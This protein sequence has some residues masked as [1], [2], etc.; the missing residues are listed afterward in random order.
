MPEGAQPPLA[1]GPRRGHAKWMG[2]DVP[3]GLRAHTVH[4]C[5]YVLYIRT[6]HTVLNCNCDDSRLDLVWFFLSCAASLIREMAFGPDWSAAIKGPPCFV[7]LANCGRDGVALSIVPQPREVIQVTCVPS[8]WSATPRPFA[9]EADRSA[10]LFRVD[11]AFPSFPA[12]SRWV[13]SPP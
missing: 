11:A 13:Q 2:R 3:H 12:L 5:M 4:V 8:A 7:G 9:P 1:G 10:A 6:A